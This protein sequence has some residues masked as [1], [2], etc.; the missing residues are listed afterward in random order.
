MGQ[1]KLF[2]LRLV[3]GPQAEPNAIYV[4]L[5]NQPKILDRRAVIRSLGKELHEP[6]EIAVSDV[7]PVSG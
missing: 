3:S 7:P 6:L 2:R 5:E 1:T 4:E